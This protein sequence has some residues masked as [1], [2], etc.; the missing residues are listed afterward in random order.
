MARLSHSTT[1]LL[2][3]LSREFSIALLNSVRFHL[4]FYGVAR[5]AA[6]YSLGTIGKV[7][8]R[9]SPRNGSKPGTAKIIIRASG[10]KL[11]MTLRLPAGRIAAS[12]LRALLPASPRG[13]QVELKSGKGGP[14]LTF[15]AHISRRG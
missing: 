14:V 3:P 10:S 6:S 12:R 11:H 1:R 9:L 5:P 13:V 4:N 15:E 7:M 8:N 2:V